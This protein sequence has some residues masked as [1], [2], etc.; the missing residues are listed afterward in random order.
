VTLK[1]YNLPNLD[2][3]IGE[4]KSHKSKYEEWR[5]AGIPPFFDF[6]TTW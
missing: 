3:T 1:T 4:Y 2:L 6:F 5:W